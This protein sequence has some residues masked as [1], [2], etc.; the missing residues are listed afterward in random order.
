MAE[1]SD[2]YSRQVGQ[3]IV[4]ARKEFPT[5]MISQRELAELVQVS[6]RS[7]QAYEAGEVIPYRK[8]K[9]LSEVLNR[10]ISWILHG[11][12][13]A[14]DSG[15]LRPALDSILAVLEEQLAVVTEIR[16]HLKS[17]GTIHAGQAIRDG[18]VS[19]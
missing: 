14:Q 13:V 10:P 6:E 18:G 8:M 19:A 11:D 5:G 7:M 16:D 1:E 12:D 2:E 4:E 9:E 15:E 3:R 17:E